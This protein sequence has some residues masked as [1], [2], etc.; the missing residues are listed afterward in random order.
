MTIVII[1]AV[2][3]TQLFIV[4]SGTSFQLSLIESNSMDP[5]LIEGDIL[6]WVPT[7]IKDI[8]IGDIVVFKSYIK[9]PNEK[10][11]AH[12]VTNIKVDKSTGNLI[13]ETKGDANDYKDQNNPTYHMP[14]IQEDYIQGKAVCFGNQPFIINLNFI[15]ILLAI[16]IILLTLIYTYRVNNSNK[17]AYTLKNIT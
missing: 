3:I 14:Y 16:S 2:I 6:V 9:W 1:F 17:I 5:T 4:L 8:K 10:L 11:I 15:F 7:K 13:L 12:R